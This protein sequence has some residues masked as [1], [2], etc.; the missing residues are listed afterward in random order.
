[1]SASGRDVVSVLSKREKVGLLRTCHIPQARDRL[2]CP[3]ARETLNMAP[4][5]FLRFPNNRIYNV[6]FPFISSIKEYPCKD[7]LIVESNLSSLGVIIKL[8]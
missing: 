5:S 7:K 6:T 3:Q 4:F 8:C 1:L 2:L